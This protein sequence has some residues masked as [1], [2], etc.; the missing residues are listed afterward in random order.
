M[1]W[2]YRGAKQS[3]LSVY[4]LQERR[5]YNGTAAHSLFRS[6]AR[7]PVEAGLL[8]LGGGGAAAISE[9]NWAYLHTLARGDQAHGDLLTKL[10][11]NFL[12]EPGWLSDGT[13]VQNEGASQP[14]CENHRKRPFAK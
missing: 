7:A 3:H 1:R 10:N 11:G 4:P 2:T 6:E 14:N 9:G 5:G 8:E 12:M 13:R